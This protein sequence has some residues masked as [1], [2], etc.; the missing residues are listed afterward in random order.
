MNILRA[1]V[2]LGWNFQET[3]RSMSMHQ[4]L[5]ETIPTNQRTVKQ[6]LRYS[7][8]QPQ[9]RTVHRRKHQMKIA[10]SQQKIFKHNEIFKC[11][12]T[13]QMTSRDHT[14]WKG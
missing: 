10:T 11:K 2:G 5:E 9:T 1:S 6:V 8:S 3:K 13:V 14:C 12:G 4:D 7:Q